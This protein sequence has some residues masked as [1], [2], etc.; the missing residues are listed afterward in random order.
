[1][2]IAS[3][4]GFKLFKRVMMF[5]LLLTVIL[6]SCGKK[7]S[8]PPAP[9]ADKTALQAKVTESQSLYSASIEGTKPGQYEAGS[10]AAFLLIITAANAV[11]LDPSA[12]QTAVTNATA[13][14]QA[15][16]DI[17]K[18][19]FIKEIAAANLIGFWKMNGNANDSSGNANNGVLTAGA[20]FPAN[21]AGVSYYGGGMPVLTADRFTRTGMAYHFDAGGNIEVP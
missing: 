20:A 2:M 10:K 6:S 19:H 18:T 15:A 4:F 3:T 11:L 9:P 5:S 14:L 7:D 13:Q 21:L 12:T 1:I 17:Y 16:I 8:T